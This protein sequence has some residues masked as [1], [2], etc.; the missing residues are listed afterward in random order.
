M[1]GAVLLIVDASVNLVLGLAL[2]LFPQPL[3]QWLGVPIPS[4]AFYPS[5]LGG[6]LIGISLALFLEH[7][8]RLVGLTGLGIGGALVINLCGASTLVVWLIWGDLHLSI[9]GFVVL[10]G[11]AAIVLGVGGL[12]LIDASRHSRRS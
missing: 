6:V 9:R 3:T 5:I 2:L 8:R 7:Y 12:E 11:I 4:S 1:R 10:W